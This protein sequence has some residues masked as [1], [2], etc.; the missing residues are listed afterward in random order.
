VRAILRQDA[1]SVDA[2]VDTIADCEVDN[3]KLSGKRYG[4]FRAFFREDGQS[5]P[6][7]T[8]KNHGNRSH[9]RPSRSMQMAVWM[10]L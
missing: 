8:G 6:F 4:R 10:W 2:A 5:R 7:P 3:P 9:G 1:D